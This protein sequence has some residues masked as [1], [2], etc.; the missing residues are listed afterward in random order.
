MTH[1]P[2]KKGYL[3]TKKRKEGIACE[4]AENKLSSASQGYWPQKE[5]VLLTTPWFLTSGLQIREPVH[6]CCF[7]LP[8][9]GTLFWQP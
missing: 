3:D 4:D 7:S 8:A 6:F 9:R 2:V 1:V 5:P